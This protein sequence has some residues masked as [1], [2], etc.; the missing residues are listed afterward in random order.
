MAGWFRLSDL[1]SGET[2]EFQPTRENAKEYCS[3]WDVKNKKWIKQGEYIMTEDGRQEVNKYTRLADE[4]KKFFRKTIRMNRTVLINGE[5][6]WVAFPRTADASLKEQM[7]TIKALGKE[8]LAFTYVLKK[9]GDG[10]GTKYKVKIGKEVGLPDSLKSKKEVVTKLD[11]TDIERKYVE[12]LKDFDNYPQAKS[13]TN[14]DRVQVLMQKL[15]LFEGR[16][17][18]IVQENF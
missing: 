17:R 3:M 18:R 2:I 14:E 9:E 7:N 16:A 13:Y 6:K 11:L 8:P 12:A 4:E 10:L 5:E 15:G 1:K